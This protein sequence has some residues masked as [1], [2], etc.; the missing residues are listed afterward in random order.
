[1]CHTP[2][3]LIALLHIIYG[4]CCSLSYIWFSLYPCRTKLDR[5]DKDFKEREERAEKLAREIE[6]NGDSPDDVGTEE[7]L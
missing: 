1:M 3:C 5:S 6:D 4:T 2:R 7:E